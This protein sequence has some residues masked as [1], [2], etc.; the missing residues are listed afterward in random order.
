MH[1]NL[2]YLALLIVSATTAQAELA[3]KVDQT[4]LPRTAEFNELSVTVTIDDVLPSDYDKQDKETDEWERLYITLPDSTEDDL[5]LHNAADLQNTEGYHPH[6]WYQ[7]VKRE[8]RSNNNGNLTV[9]WQFILKA[10]AKHKLSDLMQGAPPALQ[11][12]ISYHQWEGEAYGEALL[13]HV[14]AFLRLDGVPATAPQQL[15]LTPR[16]HRLHIDW[17]V[18]ENVEYSNAQGKFPSAGVLAIV[19][20][21][22]DT[23]IDM[24]DAAMLFRPAAEGGDMPLDKECHL[25]PDCTLD[26]G[27]NVYF[28]F[29]KIKNIKGLQNSKFLQGGT[30]VI[31]DLKPGVTYRVLLQYY[32]DGIVRSQCLT[33]V[34]VENKTLFELNGA[35]AAEREDLRCFIATA[36]WGT[37]RAVADL[38]WWRDNFLLTN[39]WG[40]AFTA[41][42]YQHAPPIAARIADYE[43]LRALTRILLL[44]PLAFVQMFK[45]PLLAILCMALFA[46]LTFLRS[47]RFQS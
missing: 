10:R 30:G 41:F 28:D 12:A 33:A 14:H 1:L 39:N 4:I 36:A 29:E 24:T 25:K 5:P 47:K 31:N 42:Y 44:V 6:F 7:A 9:T 38:R 15:K 21:A 35:D 3:I 27:D 32:P 40:R 43:L 20:A 37:S 8:K 18:P 17:Q 16:H 22:S 23:P 46:C 13:D 19:A 11:L 34:P 26:C 2:Y 45:H